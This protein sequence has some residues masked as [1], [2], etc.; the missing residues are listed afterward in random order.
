MAEEGGREKFSV[1]EYF[2]DYAKKKKK[3]GVSEFLDAARREKEEKEARRLEGAEKYE[4]LSDV[5][6][7]AEGGRE[8]EGQEKR[9]EG[10]EETGEGRGGIREEREGEKITSR[11]VA[12]FMYLLRAFAIAVMALL[13]AFVLIR[14][15]PGFDRATRWYAPAGGFLDFLLAAL[16]P[17]A[18]LFL[19]LA[20]LQLL[21]Y[22][23]YLVAHKKWKGYAREEIVYSVLFAIVGLLGSAAIVWALG[24]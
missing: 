2:A 9:R 21:Y 24:Y 19:L 17:F 15:V 11:P 22:I 14:Q 10:Q 23:V 8:S 13:M 4:R 16:V 7:K 12:V 3:K 18:A 5:A 20:G 6:K 1:D